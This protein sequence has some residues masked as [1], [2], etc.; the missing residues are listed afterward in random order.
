MWEAIV[1]NKPSRIWEAIADDVGRLMVM[2]TNL[3]RIILSYTYSF[4]VNF[5]NRFVRVQF[6][7]ALSP[8]KFSFVKHL[9]DLLLATSNGCNLS[10]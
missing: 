9:L 8:S 7:L 3:P 2:P 5:F 4:I 1:D 10:V 6:F